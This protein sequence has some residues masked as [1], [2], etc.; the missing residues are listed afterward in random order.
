MTLAPE[1]ERE[2]PFLKKGSKDTL[3]SFNKR[4]RKN[5]HGGLIYPDREE[6]GFDQLKML[7]I[8]KRS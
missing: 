1:C 8:S 2:Q 7:I 3:N 4:A 6:N 5:K